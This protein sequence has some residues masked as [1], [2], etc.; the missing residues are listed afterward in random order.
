MRYEG[1]FKDYKLNGFGRFIASDGVICKGNWKDSLQDGFGTS[2][3]IA[4]GKYI[5]EYQKN[6]FCGQGFIIYKSGEQQHFGEWAQ[7]HKNGEGT[8]LK[9]EKFRH[10]SWKKNRLGE[11]SSEEIDENSEQG[12]EI[13]NKIKEFE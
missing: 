1:L 6:K 2:G 3:E 8:E 9:N 13:R 12:Q 7:N 5:G 11:Y 4:R 10:G